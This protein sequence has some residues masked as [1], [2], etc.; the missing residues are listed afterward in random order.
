MISVALMSD[1]ATNGKGK[2]AAGG[3]TWGHPRIG[4]SMLLMELID[5]VRS[6]RLSRDM[7]AVS[8]NTELIFSPS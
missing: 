1:S 2:S 6:V 8:C 4:Q 7:G 5:F 3:I